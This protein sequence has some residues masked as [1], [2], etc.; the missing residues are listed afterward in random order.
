MILH[1][2]LPRLQKNWEQL[3]RVDP[4]W[5]VCSD[6][7]RR[8]NRWTAEEF[9]ATGET[10]VGRVIQY[11]RS[12][13]L[14]PDRSLAAL[15][16]GCGVGR[17]TRALALH[18][19]ECHGVDIS[20]TMIRMARE[21]NHDHAGCQFHLNERDDLELFPDGAFGFVYTSIV[22]QHIP[23]RLVED[24]LLELTRVLRVGG[25]LVFQVPERENASVWRK[26][27]TRMAL[28]RRFG[29]LLSRKN[30]PPFYVEMHCFPER[31]IR[32]LLSG[33]PLRLVD[34]TLTNST[35]GDFNGNLRFGEQE[36]AHGFVSKQYCLVREVG[37]SSTSR[38][39]STL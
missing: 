11:V 8:G 37:P 15:D 20:P 34:V 26:L 31:D 19:R 14:T 24:Y 29:R 36:P 12:L 7:A 5:A 30:A 28:R 35:R 16:F 33:R 18:F 4:L 23:R 13:G 27:R 21:F 22:L 6:D 39:P 17:L 10:E 25:I 3:A 9:F 38:A 32:R 1:R 2:P